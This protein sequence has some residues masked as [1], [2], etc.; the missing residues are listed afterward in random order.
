MWPGNA[1]LKAVVL[2]CFFCV[3]KGRSLPKYRKSLKPVSKF[4]NM[5]SDLTGASESVLA[6]SEK[7]A[8]ATVVAIKKTYV[9]PLITQ[10]CALVSVLLF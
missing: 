2:V 8:R 6:A 10:C 9:V 3:C 4:Y 1:L 5:D 7:E